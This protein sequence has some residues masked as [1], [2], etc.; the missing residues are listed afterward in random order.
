MSA[1]ISLSEPVAPST[2][3]EALAAERA[4]AVARATTFDRILLALIGVLSVVLIGL[5]GM[6][7]RDAQSTAAYR[8]YV[9]TQR[10]R[11]VS[12]SASGCCQPASTRVGLV[13]DLPSGLVF[14]AV[15]YF[16]GM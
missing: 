7:W 15:W 14:C 1:A 8:P 5:V 13:A 4:V 16:G 2:A 11:C 9:L 6:E 10:A 12:L 3:R